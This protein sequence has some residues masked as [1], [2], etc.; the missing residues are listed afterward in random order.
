[1]CGPDPYAFVILGRPER[2]AGRA[3][4]PCLDGCE[5]RGGGGCGSSSWLVGVLHRLARPRWRGMDPGY[6]VLRFAR[7]SFRDDDGEEP[8]LHPDV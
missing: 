4:D 2:S 3:G 5:G 6:A 8:Q 7:T 1:M